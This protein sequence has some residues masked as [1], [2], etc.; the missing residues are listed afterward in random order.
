MVRINGAVVWQAYYSAFGEAEI[1]IEEVQNNLRFPGQ[2]FDQETGLHH[3]YFR[4]YDPKL[5][6]YLQADPIGL[7]DG[8]NIYTYVK[9]NS[10]IDYDP[11]GIRRKSPFGEIIYEVFTIFDV[12]A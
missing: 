1:V 8:P 5:G 12:F 9:G 6:I 7:S 11:Y 4:D 2:Y 3:N 10:I